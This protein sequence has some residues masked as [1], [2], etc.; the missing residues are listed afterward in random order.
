MGLRT[1]IIIMTSGVILLSAIAMMLFLKTTIY[2]KLFITLQKRGSI[3]ARQIAN[4]SITPILTEKFYELDMMVKEVKSSEE[5]IEYVFILNDH[6]EVLAHTFE[7]GFPTD[8]KNLNI[9][10]NGQNQGIQTLK[11][12]DK[13]ILDIAVPILQGDVGIVHL[14]ISQDSIER[15]INKI[16][17]LVIWIILAVMTF[18]ITASIFL[19]KKITKP[20]SELTRAVKIAGSGDL[21]HTVNVSAHDEIGQLTDSFNTMIKDLKKR[22]DDLEKIN[23]ELTVLHLISAAAAGTMK[24]DD[25]FTD[26]L[27]TIINLGILEIAQKGVIFRIDGE[28]MNLVAQTGFTDAFKDAHRGIK[29][30]ECLCGLAAKTGVVVVSDSS[31]TD[32]RHT[33]K[34]PGIIPHGHICIPLASRERVLGIL[35]LYP[36]VGAEI[37]KREMALFYTIGSQVGAAIDNILLYE[38]TK[39]LSLHDPLT[40]L[41]N[42]RLMEYMLETSFARARRAECPFSAIMLDIDFFKTYND[43]YGHTVGD[44]LLINIAKILSREIRQI[45]L[46]VRYGGEE[47]LIL[48]PE[49]ELSKACDAA[50]R[51]RKDVEKIIGVTV[52]LGVSCYNPGMQKKEDIIRKA[53][54]ALLKAKQN[55]R[56]RVEINA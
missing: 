46:G 43:T 9:I 39:D 47:F 20:V 25:L 13:E 36:P 30:G 16:I 40:G 51:I 53:D 28:S 7:R 10:D 49:T 50:E 56:N 32:N 12:A 21:G 23:S 3:I 24:L 35:C 2:Q 5:N 52:S 42:R 15:D 41:A 22:K 8:L 45:D 34:Y 31:E 1:K 4:N 27:D 37:S 17:M 14:G 55:G 26:I 44:N 29:V 11:T 54:D 6:G 38:E 33:I 18:G 48:L 19:S